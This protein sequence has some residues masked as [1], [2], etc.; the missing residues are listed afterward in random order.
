M[1][2]VKD[3]E[4]EA[5]AVSMPSVL[6][7]QIVTRKITYIIVFVTLVLKEMENFVKRGML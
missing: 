3:A 1:Q 2:N 7:T 6:T 5:N 4:E